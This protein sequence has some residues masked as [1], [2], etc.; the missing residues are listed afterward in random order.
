MAVCV[1]RRVVVDRC[2]PPCRYAQIDHNRRSACCDKHASGKIKINDTTYAPG[3]PKT[4]RSLNDIGRSGCTVVHCAYCRVH[5]APC[6]VHCVRRVLCHDVQI[7]HNR[8]SACCDKTYQW[9]IKNQRHHLRSGITQNA[10]SLNDIGRSGFAPCIALCVRRVLHV[11]H[12][13]RMCAALC[14]AAGV[15]CALCVVLR[16]QRVWYAR[17]G[18]ASGARDARWRHATR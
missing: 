13:Y 2:W 17:C 10:R 4:A 3:S 9:K 12:V 5:R 14:G 7:D 6:T 1:P 15:L 16:V 8:R 18:G 11:R